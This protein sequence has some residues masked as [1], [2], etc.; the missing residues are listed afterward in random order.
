MHSVIA[1]SSGFRASE[2][3]RLW[4]VPLLVGLLVFLIACISAPATLNDGDTL[5]HIV[6]GQWI[7]DHWAIPFQDPFT[8]TAHGKTWVPH[9]WLGEVVYAT[10]YDMLGWGGVVATAAL[11]AGT[12][13]ALLTGALA[14]YF[15]PRRAMMVAL[16]AFMLCASHLMARPHVLA[17]PFLVVWMAA[18]V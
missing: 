7:L 5:T 8:F 3:A 16:L 17:W 12:A 11:V 4:L 10:A 1:V 15:G 13:F 14:P 9:E 6:V 18:V 2:R